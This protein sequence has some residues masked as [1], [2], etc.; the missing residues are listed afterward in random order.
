VTQAHDHQFDL[1]GPP[2]LARHARAEP[3]W[4]LLPDETRRAV[5]SL[6]VQLIL[7]HGSA[8]RGLDRRASDDV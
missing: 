3:T 5:M 8:D 2:S 7:E 6:M 1:F 4:R